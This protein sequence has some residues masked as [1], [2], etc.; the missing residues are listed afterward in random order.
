M[1]Q[2]QYNYDFL[3]SDEPSKWRILFSNYISVGQFELARA[4]LH[5]LKKSNHQNTVILLDRLFNE[6]SNEATSQWQDYQIVPID[7]KI[8]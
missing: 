3:C 1:A 2:Q 7:L 8:V 6:I 5:Q 4:I